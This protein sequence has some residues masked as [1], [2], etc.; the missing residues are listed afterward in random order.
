MLTSV[1]EDIKETYILITMR[2]NNNN[3]SFY[4]ICCTSNNLSSHILICRRQFRKHNIAMNH[5]E[6]KCSHVLY[7]GKEEFEEF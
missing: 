6:K 3:A 5:I 7:L 1:G 4:G 2:R